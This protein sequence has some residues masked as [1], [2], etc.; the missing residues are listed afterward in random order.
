MFLKVKLPFAVVAAACLCP[1]SVSH[2]VALATGSPAASRTTPPHNET[3]ESCC[4]QATSQEEMHNARQKSPASTCKGLR[5]NSAFER[6]NINERYLFLGICAE[7]CPSA[8]AFT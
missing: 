2:T 7:E 3:A 8:K 5:R 4:V 1:C 6:P